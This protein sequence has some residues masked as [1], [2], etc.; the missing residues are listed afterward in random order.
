M[1]WAIAP[2][3]SLFF[4]ESGE[5]ATHYATQNHLYR[6]SFHDPSAATAAL[7]SAARTACGIPAS[8]AS[9]SNQW[10][11]AQRTCY[12]DAIATGDLSFGRMSRQ[13]AEQQVEQREAMRN[14]PSFDTN[15]VPLRISVHEGQSVNLGFSATSEFSTI[16][17]YRLLSGPVGAKFDPNSGQFEWHVPKKP[18]QRQ[19]AVKV[20]AEDATYH[21]I[22]THEVVLDV[23][24]TGDAR[25]TFVSTV[26]TFAMLVILTLL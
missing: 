16:I 26:L 15:K 17:A 13:A 3:R 23:T 9:D 24:R 25:K 11:A 10:T 14:P 5:N 18:T 12:Y 22:S 19:F 1:T 2:T 21:L 6:P 8:D 20:S 7:D 4:Y